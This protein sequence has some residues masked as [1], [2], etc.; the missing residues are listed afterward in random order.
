MISIPVGVPGQCLSPHTITRGAGSSGETSHSFIEHRHEW[1]P[2]APRPSVGHPGGAAALDGRPR[3][4]ERALQQDPRPGGQ[5]VGLP[6]PKRRVTGRL[7]CLEVPP[8]DLAV[9]EEEDGGDHRPGGLRLVE[10]PRAAAS[11]P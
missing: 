2:I 6:G 3:E 8:R 11:A 9:R 7:G 4:A 1:R 5:T 10:V